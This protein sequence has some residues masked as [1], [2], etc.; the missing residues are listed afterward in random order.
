MC[1]MKIL[2]RTDAYI[3]DF[4]WGSLE[5]LDM[6]I[7]PFKLREK[8]RIRKIAIN[9]SYTV[10]FIIRGQQ[11]ISSVLDGFHVPGS[12]VTSSPDQCEFF[13]AIFFTLLSFKIYLSLLSLQKAI[14]SELNS[15]RWPYSLIHPICLAGL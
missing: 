10:K 9:N 3:V 2:G 12:D 6:P 7:K 1:I 5:L 11:V 8:V 13:H 4:I 15:S 14:P